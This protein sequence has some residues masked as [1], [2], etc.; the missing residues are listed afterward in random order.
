MPPGAAAPFGAWNRS[1]RRRFAQ[2][3]FTSPEHFKGIGPR[4]GLPPRETKFVLYRPSHKKDKKDNKK[5]NK[6]KKDK[7][8][9][10]K[11]HKTK[12]N[13]NNEKPIKAK[14]EKPKESQDNQSSGSKFIVEEDI[15]EKPV[16]KKETKKESKTSKYIDNIADYFNGLNQSKDYKSSDDDSNIENKKNDWKD[17]FFYINHIMQ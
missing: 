14:E 5:K 4:G 7:K 13:K 11:S 6:S 16:P 2:G 15:D 10:N 8:N 12:E 17:I 1:R 9:K 3:G